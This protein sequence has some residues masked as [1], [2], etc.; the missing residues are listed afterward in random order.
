MATKQITASAEVSKPEQDA[1][2]V[3]GAR[4]PNLKKV[5]LD[6]PHNSITVDTDEHPR[7]ETTFQALAALRPAFRTDGTV[8]AGNSSGIND[9]AACLLVASAEWAER[10]GRRALA[11]IAATTVDGVDPSYMGIGPVPATQTAL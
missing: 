8:T 9:G 3:Q 7:P 11:R 2:R 4:V 6:V 10:E 1:L 5:T